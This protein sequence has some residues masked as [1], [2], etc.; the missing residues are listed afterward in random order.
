MDKTT[1][2]N[3]INMNK[4]LANAGKH[5]NQLLD[6]CRDIMA[7]RLS[8]SMTT[9]MDKVDDMLFDLSHEETRDINARAQYFYA[10]REMRLKRHDIESTFQTKFNMLFDSGVRGELD[11][12]DIQ[13]RE[14]TDI[15]ESVALENTITKVNNDCREA[16]LYLDQRMGKLL[17]DP[18]LEKVIIPLRPEV[19]CNAFQ[20][21]CEN[22]ESDIEI[23]LIL[24]KLFDKYVTSGLQD[25]YIDIN[26]LLSDKTEEGSTETESNRKKQ[27][28]KDGAF[29][30]K[31]NQLI[32]DEIDGR[33]GVNSLPE[34]ARAFLYH[35]WSKLLLKIYIRDGAD[36]SAWTHAVDAIDDMVNCI[37][38]NTSTKEKK[39]L[40]GLVPNLKQRLRYG[41]NVIP[42]PPMLRDEFLNELSQYYIGL[43][44][45]PVVEDDPLDEQD[46]EDVT[47]PVIALSKHDIPFMS[48][49]LVDN[50]DINETDDDMNG[51]K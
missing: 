41:M 11:V 24:F 27:N 21:A 29:F 46:S 5:S 51:D 49:L 18:N 43:L 38:G 26:N 25:I 30:L 7:S 36:G 15:E 2:N 44:E 35:Y 19:V 1:A 39:S 14:E 3:I 34:F 50:K 33:A 6:E 13:L 31:A 37:G 47:V 23:K 4:Y 12:E 9:M 10:M 42:V 17:G 8:Q 45:I 22:I 20:E 32:K 28:I 48:E 40:A 16:L